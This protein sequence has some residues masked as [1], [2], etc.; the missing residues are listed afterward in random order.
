[1]PCPMSDKLLSPIEAGIPRRV[2]VIPP[3]NTTLSTHPLGAV[4]KVVWK[5]VLS[6]FLVIPNGS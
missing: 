6:V 3:Q 2:S 4:E 1:M 5:I